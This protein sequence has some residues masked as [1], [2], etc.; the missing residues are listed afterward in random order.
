MTTPRFEPVV[1]EPT[2]LQI[3][4]ILSGVDEAEFGVVRDLLD[5][6]DSVLSKH[7]KTLEQVGY[8][9]L[10]KR[11]PP[12]GRPRTWAALTNHGRTAFEKHVA[13]LQRLAA[14]ASPAD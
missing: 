13:E 7:L 4:G 12:V 9:S 3:C 6:A 5:V 11:R 8:V 2:R 10:R 1:H 14:L